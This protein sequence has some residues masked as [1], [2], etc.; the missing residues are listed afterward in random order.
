MD[1]TG[2]VGDADDWHPEVVKGEGGF[3]ADIAEALDDD[4][5]LLGLDVEVLQVGL[6]EPG[7]AFARG[8]LA[9]QRTAEGD[10]L[11]G[12]DARVEVPL[13]NRCPSSRP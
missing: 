10:R 3:A 2:V 6:D 13:V 4:G 1:T 5:G 11:A 7:D 12:D 9:A 8:L